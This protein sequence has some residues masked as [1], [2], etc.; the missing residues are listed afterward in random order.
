MTIAAIVLAA[1][2]S[3]RFGAK[4]KLLAEIGGETLIRRSVS[5]AAA[6]GASPVIVVT[7]QDAEAV[8]SV[9][10][11]L[12]VRLI[13]SPDP[14][15][16]MGRSVAAGI[17]AVPAGTAGALV[18][19]GDMPAIVV[20]VLERLMAVFAEN[21]ATRIVYPSDSH[22]TQRNPVLWPRAFF[23]ELIRL[24]GPK[25]GKALL[26]AHSASAIAVPFQDDSAFADIDTE[27]DLA[28]Y[29]ARSGSLNRR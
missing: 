10:G 15:S 26:A 9:L 13:P 12:N 20:G 8:R 25:G 22:G 18:L 23:P 24:D 2:S 11:G 4:N 7:G 5:A 29:M 16:G 28:A 27:A 14:Q 17:G 3:K 1:G 6:S 19:P 21:G